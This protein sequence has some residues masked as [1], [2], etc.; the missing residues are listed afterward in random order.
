MFVSAVSATTCRV[1]AHWMGSPTMNWLSM[2]R[3]GA[4]TGSRATPCGPMFQ[5]SGSDT[6]LAYHRA[7]AVCMPVWRTSSRNWMW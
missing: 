3:P 5:P 1:N 6:F 7:S 2:F 4:S